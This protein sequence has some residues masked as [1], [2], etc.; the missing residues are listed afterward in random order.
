MYCAYELNYKF[1]FF[2]STMHP[3]ARSL[4]AL[5]LS[6]LHNINDIFFYKI[7][8]FHYGKCPKI[9]IV[10]N[11][12]IRS[13]YANCTARFD[14]F[15][16]CFWSHYFHIFRQFIVNCCFGFLWFVFYAEAQEFCC[17]FLF[18]DFKNCTV[19]LI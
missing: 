12:E 17:D 18:F 7:K 13:T 2:K 9:K 10:K 16:F 6:T 5:D 4:N 15:M 1:N 11:T 8:H 3:P 19:E 14:L